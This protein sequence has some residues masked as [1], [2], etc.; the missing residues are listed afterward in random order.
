MPSVGFEIPEGVIKNAIA[1]AIADS[2]SP[3]KRE[4]I[5][6]D[7]VRAHLEVKADTYSRETILAKKIGDTIRTVAG[8]EVDA[9]IKGEL[10]DRIRGAVREKLGDAFQ[11]GVVEA[12]RCSMKNIVLANLRVIV[13]PME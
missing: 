3:E 9:I 13:T 4:Q 1:I 8:E 2:F 6:R 12:V 5:I 10:S 7:I 11:D